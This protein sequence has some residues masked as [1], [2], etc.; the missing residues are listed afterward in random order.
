M[1]RTEGD[2]L[3]KRVD[4]LTV[5]GRRRREDCEGRDLAGVGGD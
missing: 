4:A 5:E 3:T 1:T 2:R